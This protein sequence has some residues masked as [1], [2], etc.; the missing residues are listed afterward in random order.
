MNRTAAHLADGRRIVYF[1]RDGTDREPEPDLRE[2]PPAAAAS[3]MRF[4]PLLREWVVVASHRQGRTH[5][6]PSDDCPLC[7]SSGGRRT[8]VPASA[9]D[10]VAFENRFPSLVAGDGRALGDVGELEPSRR[11]GAGRCEVLVFASDHRASFA[12]LGPER[13]NLVM[14][15][16]VD[17][18]REL[19]ALPGVE[20]VYCFENRGREI[21]VTLHHPHGQIYALPF[22][23]PRTRRM[24]DSAGEYAART[25]G[26]LFGDLL[27]A[28]QKAGLRVVARTAHWT[29]F[30]PAAARWPV[31][32][33]L[34]PHR[35][36]PDLPALTPQERED[37]GLLYLDV[38][39]RFDALYD[40]PLPYISAW[41]QAP[42]RE[43]RDLAWLHL[44]LFSVRRAA[45][46][47]K[48]L[49]GTESGMDVFISDVAPEDAA[50][51]LRAA[52]PGEE[53]EGK[54]P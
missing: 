8:E 53:N 45:D 39:R 43:R 18:T 25:G 48:H 29:A 33:H 32:V 23:A 51:R 26:D 21:G 13:A 37:F 27:A 38:L 30:V 47:L 52:G 15:A 46:K 3:E 17:R 5:L 40:A 42:V 49:A 1:D 41:H 24:L 11:T 12:D 54:A 10:V 19:S 20:Q 50:E 6:P 44:E 7:P 22:V 2:L 16:W 28:E 14:E 9:Y 4:D 36:V 35:K 34:Y 31:E